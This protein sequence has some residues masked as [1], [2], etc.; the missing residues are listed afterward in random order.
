MTYARS[1]LLL[2]MFGVG[3]IVVLSGFLL[4][5]DLPLKL[6]PSY[7]ISGSLPQQADPRHQGD[8]A[9]PWG[10]R[11][12]A[13]SGWNLVYWT[14]LMGP[15]DAPVAHGGTAQRDRFPATHVQPMRPALPTAHEDC[16]HV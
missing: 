8:L 11:L 4:V 12:S 5:T 2:G 7:H 14:G 6:L 13:Q 3:S 16:C 1:R 9:L 15:A 10:S